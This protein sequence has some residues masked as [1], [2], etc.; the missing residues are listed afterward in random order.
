MSVRRETNTYLV[1]DINY[2]ARQQKQTKFK[3]WL[4]MKDVKSLD[5][6]RLSIDN[7]TR[8]IMEELSV[9]INLKIIENRS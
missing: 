7:S 3:V 6:V 2:K 8:Y 1:V 5:L 9:T 4:D